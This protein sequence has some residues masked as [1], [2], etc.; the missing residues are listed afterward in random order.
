MT[1]LHWIAAN[2]ANL[3]A[4]LLL[5]G[6]L[7]VV[8]EWGHFVAFRRFRVPVEVFAIGFGPPLWR[9]PLASGTEL[10]LCP[11]PVG[12]YVKPDEAAARAAA[13]HAKI[14]IALAGP[15]MNAVA[16]ALFLV[17][18]ALA[19]GEVHAAPEVGK[20]LAGSAAAAAG[21]EPGDRIVAVAGAPVETFEGLARAVHAHPGEAIE[22]V[23]ERHGARLTLTLTP[24][25]ES[26]RIGV[27]HSGATWSRRLPPVQAV[28][29]GLHEAWELTARTVAGFVQLVT[30][31]A[32]ASS[33]GG[34]IMIFQMATQAARFGAAALVHFMA[35]ISIA[36]FVFNLLPVPPLDGGHVLFG[37]VEA[38]RGKA[39][40]RAVHAHPGE[41]IEVVVERH[42]ARLTLTLTP[43][44]KSGRIGVT[45]SGATW[46]RRLG[47]AQ[48]VAYGLR[49][50]WELTARTV[51][52][53]VQLVTRKADASSV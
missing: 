9:R 20:V 34:P 24:D 33:V 35:V 7:I 5:L 18:L 15:A 8:H 44:P 39:L 49:E 13:P 40:A 21:I 12:G 10:R 46:S 26:G 38:I 52:G 16:G 42:G 14:L 28:A 50:A 4:T 6:V 47:P 11:I 32:D 51:A 43:D 41:A 45:H 22:V 29:Y 17:A 23:V 2:A 25:P 1:F 53:F 48:A 31:K 30:R 3:A 36:L 19:Q 37:A 27:T